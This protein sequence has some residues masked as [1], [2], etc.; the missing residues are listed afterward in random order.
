MIFRFIKNII[1]FIKCN[2]HTSQ[3]FKDLK[4]AAD[5][6]YNTYRE[7]FLKVGSPALSKIFELTRQIQIDNNNLH[8]D[9]ENF[10]RLFFIQGAK[11]RDTKHWIINNY[12][13]NTWELFLRVGAQ[14]HQGLSVTSTNDANVNHNND[15]ATN[16]YTQEIQQCLS[17]LGCTFTVPG[18][19]AAK[20]L[21]RDR[22][23]RDHALS[24]C[25]GAMAEHYR[26]RE[27][28]FKATLE[29]HPLIMRATDMVKSYY[30][31]NLISQY[32][33][34]VIISFCATCLNPNRTAED[35]EL[36]ESLAHHNYLGDEKLVQIEA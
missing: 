36:I 7:F 8:L 21:K 14:E 2:Y 23:A 6:P 1:N 11:D 22:S 17:D 27:G 24:L 20:A 18:L 13:I 5:S 25:M 30:K 9:Y 34:D 29:G 16:D 28:L 12:G 33:H 26:G 31:E 10:L 15:E 32:A 4:K 19:V 35:E 3:Y